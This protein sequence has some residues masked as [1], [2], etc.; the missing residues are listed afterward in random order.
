MTPSVPSATLRAVVAHAEHS[1][2]EM[3]LRQA[4]VVHAQALL[5]LA[6]FAEAKREVERA[7]SMAATPD[8]RPLA[9]EQMAYARAL[10]GVGEHDR[11]RKLARTAIANFVA[12]PMDDDEE[13]EAARAW[14]RQEDR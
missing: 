1:H 11:A 5:E 14:L 8:P 2:D 4:L 3:Y 10:G 13:L 12:V 6:R 9:T 7:R